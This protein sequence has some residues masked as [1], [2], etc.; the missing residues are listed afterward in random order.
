MLHTKEVEG[1]AS[2]LPDEVNAEAL[3]VAVAVGVLFE[4][5]EG[6]LVA[7]DAGAHARVYGTEFR[8]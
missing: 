8:G 4:E 3:Q 1:N 2:T 7:E 5:V 6:F